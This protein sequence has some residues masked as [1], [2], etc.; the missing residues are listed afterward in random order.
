MAEG[1][2]RGGPK[3]SGDNQI[4]LNRM[5]VDECLGSWLAYI[6]MLNGLCSAGTKL[7]L[8][9][10]ALLSVHDR[11]ARCRVTAQCLAGW[12]EL[13]RAT[14]V[15]SHTVKK[16]V[17][18]AM[19]DYEVLDND[20]EKHDILRDNLL[21]FINLQYQFC[22][23]C[24]KCLG[25]MAECSCTQDGSECDIAALQQCFER[26]Y[27]SPTPASSSST[28]QNPSQHS[29]HR[30]PLPYSLFPLQVKR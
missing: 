22:V 13:T 27:S 12:E 5:D 18:A 17:A 30:S 19:K 4:S 15:A 29:S 1:G 23:A 2:G 6:K 14:N 10:Q 11:M 28:T 21:T 20:A 3:S 7:A 16:H 8:S 26:L 24:C 9:L 25:S